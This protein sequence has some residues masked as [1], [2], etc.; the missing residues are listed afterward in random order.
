MAQWNG[1]KM[2]K[3]A[4]SET[5]ESTKIAQSS[6]GKMAKIAQSNEILSR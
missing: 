1:V 4:Q 5:P 2:A 3:I 6:R